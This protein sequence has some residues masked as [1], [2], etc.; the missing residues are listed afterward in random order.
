V[1]ARPP[2]AAQSAELVDGAEMPAP[3]HRRA[4]PLAHTSRRFV[5]QRG[6]AGKSAPS[7]RTLLVP[8]EQGRAYEQAANLMLSSAVNRNKGGCT[9]IQKQGDFRNIL[10]RISTELEAH[11]TKWLKH[12]AIKS[13][14]RGLETPCR[15]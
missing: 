10:R 7:H 15:E 12:W 4:L 13:E 14:G 6:P 3:Q 9:L 2:A 5:M 1:N 11:R 8:T